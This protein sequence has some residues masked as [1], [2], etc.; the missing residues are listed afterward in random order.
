LQSAKKLKIAISNP[1]NWPY[2]RRGVERFINEGAPYLS[3][4]GH[5]VTVVCG[6]PG[7]S[8]TIVRDGYTTRFYR[9]LWNPWFLR[10]GFLEFHA[11]FFRALADFLTHKYDVILC[12][13]F[14]D[15]FA[16][17]IARVFTG[18]P[19]VFCAF[20]IPPRVQYFRTMTL[21]GA[22]YK[23]AILGADRFVGLSHYV[24]DYFHERWGANGVP[25][26]VPID[27]DHNWLRETS[28]SGPPVILCAAAIDDARKGGFVLMNA[29]NIVKEKWPDAILQITWTIHSNY[30]Q[31]LLDLVR[32]EWRKDLHF[33]GTD[34]ALPPLYRIANVC[35]L[36]SLWEAQG[37]VVLESLACGTPVV[38]T[39]DGALPEF[40]GDPR[41]SRIFDPGATSRLEPSNTEGLAQAL[42][43]AIDLS[44]L[45]ETRLLCRQH[46]M[47][48]NWEHIGPKWEAILLSAAGKETAQPEHADCVR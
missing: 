21:K 33:L 32:P 8:E 7:K 12:C 27:T 23:R 28:P 48:F 47:Q 17:Q 22:I 9:R 44:Y 42:L 29:F 34:V 37:L 2:L 39:R 15:A 14:I 26:P 3:K 30:E 18:T 46:A 38:V 1:T 45:P 19:Y 24:L 43:E 10:V 6:K 16:A 5:E 11:F 25:I 13:T 4:L 41:V 36:P 31:S 35:V 40:H 20:A